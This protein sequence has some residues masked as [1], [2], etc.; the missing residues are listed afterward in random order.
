[1]PKVSVEHRAARRQQILDAARICFLRNGFHATTMQDV[2]TQAGLSAGAVYLYFR[3]KDEIVR[4][5]AL[6]AIT[7]IAA[8]LQPMVD[9]PGAPAPIYD[10]IAAAVTGLERLDIERGVPRIALQ[11]WGEAMRSPEMAV[12][13]KDII[14]TVAPLMVRLVERHRDLGSLPPEA[15]V[16]ATARALMGLVPGFIVQRVLTGLD[17]ATYLEGLRTL[18]PSV[19]SAVLTASG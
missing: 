10:V 19:T 17:A 3:G 9:A 5:I 1:M 11:V 15:P 7:E 18:L 13:V 14:E 8:T 16:H 2:F 6:E 4:A 12:E